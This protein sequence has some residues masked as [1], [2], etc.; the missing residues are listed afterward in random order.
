MSTIEPKVSVIVPIYKVEKYIRKCAIHLLEQTI[1]SIEI[2]FI[3]DCGQDKS[4]DILLE[5]IK[6][7]PQRRNSVKVYRNKNNI[8]LVANRQKG[9]RLATG[10]YI[11]HCD[12]DDW[13]DKN[14]YESLYNKAKETNSD[15]AVCP[16]IW[17]N[18]DSSVIMPLPQLP[19]TCQ[20]LLKNWYRICCG[21]NHCNK[22]VKRSIVAEHDIVPYDNTG[23][24]EDASF[25]FRAFY[26]MGG[27]TQIDNA[28]YHYNRTNINATTFSVSRIGVDRLIN[29][30]TL[31]TDFFNNQPNKDDYLK[32]CHAIQYIAK[33]D[34]I[35][36]HFD[37][38]R[39]FHRIFP[40][41]DYIKHE[42]SRNAF[43]KRGYFRF[44]F[45]KHH[46][47]WLFVFMYK[48]YSHIKK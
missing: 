47:A 30:A 14:L 43:S 37:W 31:L 32:T 46:L 38:L 13:V 20:E 21:M 7:Y 10:E 41:S 42:L 33:L 18:T 6:K 3:D 12:S 34:L 24:W 8:G 45:V 2:I 40:D 44:W 29:A 11:T 36:T 17:E 27:I 4:M 1:D 19:D 25:M 16:F 48:T 5:T 39:D 26:Y 22:I 23:A 9:I 15:V 35:D 28:F